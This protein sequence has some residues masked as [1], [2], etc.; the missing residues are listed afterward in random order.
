MARLIVSIWVALLLFSPVSSAQEYGGR[1][2]I[3]TIK[4]PDHEI[5]ISSL[6]LGGGVYVIWNLKSLIGEPVVIGKGIV[7]IPDQL[8]YRVTY[9]NKVYT[10]PADVFKKIKPISVNVKAKISPTL[11]MDIDLGVMSDVYFGSYVLLPNLPQKDKYLSSNIQG[12]PEWNDL[13]YTDHL[14]LS[15]DY[16]G[17]LD[18]K[19]LFAGG[20]EVITLGSYAEAT[21]DLNPIKNWI[22]HQDKNNASAAVVSTN[23]KMDPFKKFGKMDA[24][25]TAKELEKIDEDI[26]EFILN[27]CGKYYTSVAEFKGL[28]LTAEYYGETNA[29]RKKRKKRQA[30]YARKHEEKVRRAKQEAKQELPEM[31]RKWKEKRAAIRDEGRMYV[32]K[33]YGLNYPMDSLDKLLEK[34]FTSLKGFTDVYY[35]HY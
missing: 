16:L 15:S 10:V 13:F 5:T 31:Q 23:S 21:F 19:A 26:K 20:I 8:S 22:E 17:E 30:A 35:V 9:K 24:E 25:P 2:T 7:S 3:T 18:A 4:T 28:V 14:G 12:S 6:N 1:E 11:F 33:K 29:E 34:N 32:I 27:R